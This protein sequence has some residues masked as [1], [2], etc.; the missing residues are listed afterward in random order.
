MTIKTP[1]VIKSVKTTKFAKTNMKITLPVC[2]MMEGLRRGCAAAF[3]GGRDEKL[4]RFTVS[5]TE[6]TIESEHD[7]NKV[8]HRLKVGIPITVEREGTCVF[9]GD[10]L[11]KSL[12]T[13]K[14]SQKHV[15]TLDHITAKKGK[16]SI[17]ASRQLEEINWGVYEDGEAISSGSL[18]PY[19]VCAMTELLPITHEDVPLLEL[20]G[21]E[22]SQI[23]GE[24]ME[25]MSA[26]QDYDATVI[27]LRDGGV[28]LV[29]IG[30]NHAL[31]RRISPSEYIDALAG[32]H[33]IGMSMEGLKI[34]DGVL[35]GMCRND[36]SVK[37]VKL[38]LSGNGVQFIW[39]VGSTKLYFPILPVLPSKRLGYIPFGEYTGTPSL[40]LSFTVEADMLVKRLAHAVCANMRPS[41]AHAYIVG[42]L[43]CFKYSPTAKDNHPGAA[44]MLCRDVEGDSS[45]SFSID[46]KLIHSFARKNEGCKISFEIIPL[47]NNGNMKDGKNDGSQIEAL[48]RLRSTGNPKV[49]LTMGS[50]VSA[51]TNPVP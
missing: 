2:D 31:E 37:S 39:E 13:M 9:K 3:L 38:R 40:S 22:A 5:K 45:L 27:S 11:Y 18:R 36:K 41:E 25:L 50:S 1:Q 8:V 43:L 21:S 12:K 48:L 19:P 4:V 6:I 28:K 29:C 7:K 23:I 20:Y 49:T 14:P 34:L 15:L 44:T 32:K 42:C 10:L 46:P 24:L 16:S 47:K 35:S 26:K 33:D 51:L 30:G 17:D